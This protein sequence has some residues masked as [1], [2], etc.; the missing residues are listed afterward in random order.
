MNSKIIQGLLNIAKKIGRWVIR[1]L[2]ERG[3]IRLLGYMEGKIDDFKRRIARIEKFS[4][5]LTKMSKR[6]IAWIQ[7]RIRNWSAAVSWISN[8]NTALKEAAV[9]KFDKEHEEL[10]HI[11][12]DTEPGEGT[13]AAA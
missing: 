12:M 11:A 6:R 10:Q 9:R 4:K 7:F 2:S 3:A 5:K 13:F 1:R 8:N